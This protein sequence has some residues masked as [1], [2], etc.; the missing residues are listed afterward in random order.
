M[1]KINLLQNS[2][3]RSNIDAVESVISSSGTRLVMLGGV[4]LAASILAGVLDYYRVMREHGSVSTE[5]EAERKIARTLE[6][7]QKEV[8]AMQKKNRAV[9][10]RI[11]AIQR[12]RADQVG[13]LRLLQLVDSRMPMDRDMRLLSI[14]QNEGSSIDIK[15]YAPSEEKVTEFARN[16]ELSS[17]VFSGFTIATKRAKNPEEKAGK[18][19]AGKNKLEESEVIEFAITCQYM[20]EA[21]LANESGQSAPAAGKQDGSGTPAAGAGNAARPV[22]GGDGG[23][24]QAPKSR[25]R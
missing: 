25:I 23:A 21:L 8:T 6:E 5:V 20:P 3:E 12:L 10:D 16:M 7:L 18:V 22:T 17:E 15:G 1:I 19:P 13:P 11:N 4:I 9:E 14:K 2:V 24:E